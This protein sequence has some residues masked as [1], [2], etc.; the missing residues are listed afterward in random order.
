LSALD[1]TVTA[2]E[3][4]TPQGDIMIPGNLCK[5]LLH[6]WTGFPCVRE[7]SVV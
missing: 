7:G 4:A 3:R 1:S 2:Y 5:D 6:K